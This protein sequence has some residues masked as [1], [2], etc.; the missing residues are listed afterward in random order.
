MSETR[1]NRTDAVEVRRMAINAVRAARGEYDS[2]PLLAASYV[3]DIRGVS[4]WYDGDSESAARWTAYVAR[5][6]AHAAREFG[7]YAD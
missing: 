6:L 2:F 5:S 7:V 1:V 4:L 3:R